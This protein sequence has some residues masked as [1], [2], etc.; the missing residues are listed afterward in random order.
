MP[1]G[2]AGV[3]ALAALLCEDS[4]SRRA[5]QEDAAT[6]PLTSAAWLG[7][8]ALE[9]RNS[10]TKV[11]Q[12]L[13]RGSFF[14][15]R[16][17]EKY[18]VYSVISGRESAN[19]I[20]CKGEYAGRSSTVSSSRPFLRPAEGQHRK[21]DEVSMFHICTTSRTTRAFHRIQSRINFLPL[22]SAA[23]FGNSG[24]PQTVIGVSVASPCPKQEEKSGVSCFLP[25]LH[26]LAF[27][28][29]WD[30]GYILAEQRPDVRETQAAYHRP[31]SVVLPFFVPNPKTVRCVVLRFFLSS[32]FLRLRY[33]LNSLAERSASILTLA[34]VF[35]MAFVGVMA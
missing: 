29:L 4:D 15:V 32:R 28:G 9:P 35:F 25:P 23:P 14:S 26:P 12:H 8:F 17:L 1:H 19:R 24:V 34:A 2:A 11:C 20:P 16:T 5:W 21:I 22:T 18:G 31:G 7:T 27:M 3:P 13:K 30:C 6:F 33:R 10:S